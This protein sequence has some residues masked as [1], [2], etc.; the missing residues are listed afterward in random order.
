MLLYA[1]SALVEGMKVSIILRVLSKNHARELIGRT[2]NFLVVNA[3]FILFRGVGV[4]TLQDTPDASSGG[5]YHFSPTAEH[6]VPQLLV[7]A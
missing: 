4:H 6:T 5:D 3:S 2:R 7:M 1:L